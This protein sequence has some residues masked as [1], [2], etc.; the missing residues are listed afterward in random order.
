[1]YKFIIK[2]TAYNYE[3]VIHRLA[4]KHSRFQHLF[5]GILNISDFVRENKNNP[6]FIFDIFYYRSE[7]VYK[8]IRAFV[9]KNWVKMSS[10]P[11]IASIIDG[12][13][14]DVTPLALPVQDDNSHQDTFPDITWVLVIYLQMLSK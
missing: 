9:K 7:Y 3:F 2:K 12:G 4:I 10:A 11:S 6:I 14:E 5:S 1:M 8:E 13:V